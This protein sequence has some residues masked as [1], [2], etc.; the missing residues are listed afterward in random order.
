[1]RPAH[2]IPIADIGLGLWLLFA[3]TVFV[4]VLANVPYDTMDFRGFFES[5]L[6]WREGRVQETVATPGGKYSAPL[7]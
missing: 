6:A 1:M 5:G 4:I 3:V 2:R 7:P